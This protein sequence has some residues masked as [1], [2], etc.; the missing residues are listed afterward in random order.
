MKPRR[1]HW[2]SELREV[3]AEGD[4]GDGGGPK[5]TTTKKTT[6]T[7]QVIVTPGMLNCLLAGNV[8]LET[9][10]TSRCCE[11]MGFN[12]S[13]EKTKIKDKIILNAIN[14]ARRTAGGGREDDIC[15]VENRAKG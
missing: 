1:V 4:E 13:H 12:E 14:M 15:E 9:G 3:G 11:C 2:L 6:T 5:P 10:V 8:G 7:T